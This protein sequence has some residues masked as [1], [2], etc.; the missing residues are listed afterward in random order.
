MS[1][2]TF[3]LVQDAIVCRDTGVVRVKGIEGE[4]ATYEVLDQATAMAPVSVD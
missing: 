3:Q 4:I 2:N 1:E